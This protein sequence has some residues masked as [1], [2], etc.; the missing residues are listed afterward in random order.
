[1]IINKPSRE[2]KST[3][4]TLHSQSNLC[5]PFCKNTELEEYEEYKDAARRFF[6]CKNCES[7]FAHPKCFLNAQ[8]QRERYLLHRN[9][10]EPAS[11]KS[12]YRGFLARFA[13]AALAYA[14]KLV[15]VTS[16]FDYGS[17]PE[18]ALVHLLEEYKTTNRLPNTVEIRGWDPF[19][20]PDTAFFK[21]GADLVLCLEVA[22]HFE[23]PTE[24]FK[25]LARAARIGG[26]VALQTLL[27]PQ[28]YAEFKNW[29]YKEDTT[30][31]SFYSLQALEI[32]AKNAGLALEA[33]SDTVFFFRRI[34]PYY[35]EFPSPL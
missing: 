35:S 12:G 16:I 14:N 3:K 13:D 32:C 6:R 19:F 4:K 18:P 22:E 27:V 26:I 1:M 8:E 34:A 17:G 7:V 31:V 2:K 15:K 24:G 28:N 10:L 9:N 25:G 29:W 30:H 33:H 23:N 20:A 11:K 5:C 21:N